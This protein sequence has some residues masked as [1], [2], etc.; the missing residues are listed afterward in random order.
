MPI[1]YSGMENDRK[2]SGH[3]PFV[4]PWSSI[5][6]E[7]EMHSVYNQGTGW[8]PDRPTNFDLLI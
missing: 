3:L 8:N 2:S 6:Y 1:P 5:S 4:P 7:K